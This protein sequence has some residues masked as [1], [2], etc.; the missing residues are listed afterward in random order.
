MKLFQ[1]F[2]LGVALASC[3]FAV[4]AQQAQQEEAPAQTPEEARA[5]VQR[6]VSILRSF[7]VAMNSEQLTTQTR[8]QIFACMYRNPIRRISNAAARVIDNNPGLEHDNPSH[9]YAAAIRACGITLRRTNDDES[10]GGQGDGPE[11]R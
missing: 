9:I 8:G 7:N 4:Q 2:A 6:G 3:S 5:A 10:E 11:G 1:K